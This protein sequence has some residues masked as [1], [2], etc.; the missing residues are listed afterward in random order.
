MTAAAPGIMSSGLYLLL[1]CLV[2]AERENGMG[3]GG[4]KKNC[5]LTANDMEFLMNVDS[6]CWKQCQLV[7]IFFFRL[8]YEDYIELKGTTS[9]VFPLFELFSSRGSHYWSWC[10]WALLASSRTSPT[11]EQ[12]LFQKVQQTGRTTAL[13]L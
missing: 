10:Q 6:F 3:M 5:L 13:I 4:C 2:Y 11:S 12:S 9:R 1:D 8:T 7:E